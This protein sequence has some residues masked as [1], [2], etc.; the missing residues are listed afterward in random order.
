[1]SNDEGESRFSL[2]VRV[3]Y[4][5]T[6]TRGTVHHANSLKFMERARIECLRSLGIEL[7]ALRLHEGLLFVVRHAE[8]TYLRPA[9]F[10]DLLTV[11]TDLCAKGRVSMDF[12]HEVRR[13]ADA[14][15]C[16]RGRIQVACVDAKT[17]RPRRLPERL[18]AEIADAC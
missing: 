6:D 17:L 4:E 11:T 14:T 5:D 10:N 12:V 15:L 16:C 18:L 9:L 1:M 3:Y 7:D 2:P 13:A 8:S